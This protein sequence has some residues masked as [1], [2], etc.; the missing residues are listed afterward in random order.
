VNCNKQEGI[1]Y[2][3]DRQEPSTQISVKVG[4][5]VDSIENSGLAKFEHSRIY[6]TFCILPP[7][8]KIFFG[9]G[10]INIYKFCA[11]APKNN[12]WW[13]QHAKKVVS[14]ALLLH[15]SAHK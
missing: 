8:K 10:N 14:F 15:K 13:R 2:E 6:G 9:E 11:S 12:F 1:P 4:E 7:P 3:T 5:L